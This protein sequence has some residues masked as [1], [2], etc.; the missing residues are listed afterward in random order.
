MLTEIPDYLAHDYREATSELEKLGFTFLR[1]DADF[2]YYELRRDDA[3][4]TK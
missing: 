3:A 4:A 2:K 1:E